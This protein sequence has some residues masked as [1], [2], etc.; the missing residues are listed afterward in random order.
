MKA[1]KTLALVL[2]ILASALTIALMC[3]QITNEFP[4]V[5]SLGQKVRSLVR[6]A[7]THKPAAPVVVVGLTPDMNLTAAQAQF[8]EQHRRRHQL[9]RTAL[10]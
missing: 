7:S 9:L 1:L 2:T 10:Q 3:P 6:S 4:M 5:K 8:L